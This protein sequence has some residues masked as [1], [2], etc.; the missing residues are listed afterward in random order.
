MPVPSVRDITNFPAA[1]TLRRNGQ[2][3]ESDPQQNTTVV[4]HSS[5]TAN[6]LVTLALPVGSV[7]LGDGSF[8]LVAGPVNV[9]AGT[10]RNVV[11]PPWRL[12][13]AAPPQVHNL[14]V[15]F[16]PRYEG[17]SDTDPASRTIV[18]T[19]ASGVT[20]AEVAGAA[21]LGA[22]VAVGVGAAMTMRKR[23][24]AKSTTLTEL[25][26]IDAAVVAAEDDLPQPRQRASAKKAP[27]RKAPAKKSATKKPAPKK[28][29]PAKKPSA[30]KTTGS[31]SSA[32]K[33]SSKSRK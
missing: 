20:M 8:T 12:L 28:A 15:R 5:V 11:F 18:I 3:F 21:A 2:V 7:T 1:L 25:E 33:S 4:V 26:R 27:A 29:S 17:T 24:K 19:E 23:K 31:K 6:V 9:P 14:R 32:K 13:R 10:T 16:E 30:R 22:A